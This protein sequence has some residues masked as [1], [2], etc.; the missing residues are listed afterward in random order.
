MESFNPNKVL[1]QN[2]ILK[3]AQIHL[4]RIGLCLTNNCDQNNIRNH[5]HNPILMFCIIGI[6]IIKNIISLT[7]SEQD[8]DL[9]VIT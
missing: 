1:P 8:E 9:L 4:Y 3:S 2:M 7:L 5:F 6:S